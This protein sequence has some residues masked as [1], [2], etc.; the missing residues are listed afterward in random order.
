MTAGSPDGRAG[1]WP[2]PGTPGN[3]GSATGHA[4]LYQALRDQY[5]VHSAP[6]PVTVER[7]LL[8][9]EPAFTGREAELAELA[10][11]AESAGSAEPAGAGRVAI[12]TIDGMPGVGKT[13][14]ALRAAH[15]LAGHYPDGQI[16]LRL[17]AHSAGHRP[18]DPAEA[19][20]EL[21]RGAGVDPRDLPEGLDARAALWRDRLAGRRVLLVLDDAEGPAQIEPLLPGTGGCLVLVTSRRRVAALDGATPMALDTLPPGDAVRLFARLARREPLAG[22]A[23]D[24]AR[25]LVAL[26]GRLPLAV[27]LL[28]GRLAH[29]PTWDLAEFTAELSAAHDRLGQLAAGERAVAAAFETSYRA[30]PT[31]RR[32]LFRRLGLHPGT[33]TEARATAA[34]V[35]LP[36]A[37]AGEALEALYDDHLVDSP[38]RG[39]YQLHDLMHV[40]ARD[41]ALRDPEDDRERAV[42]RLLDHYGHAAERADQH[43][44]E[45]PRPT[46]AIGPAAPD[47]TRDTV[48]ELADRERALAWMRAERANLVACARHATAAGEGPRALRLTAALAAFLNLQG[49]WDE[50]AGLQRAAATVARAVGDRRAEAGALREEG[51]VRAVTGDYAAAA[52]LARRAGELYA[53]V[54]DGLGEAVTLVELGRTHAMTGE[55]APAADLFR[56]ALARYTALDS[57]EGQAHAR[58]DFGQLLMVT[59]D[60]AGAA[61]HLAASL[62]RYRELDDRQG[63]AHALRE[64]GRVRVLSGDLDAAVGLFEQAIDLYRE[65]GGR[66]GEA[67]ALGELGRARL[68]TGEPSAAADLAQQV[69]DLCRELGSR[70]GEAT[71]LLELGRARV[72]TGELPAAERLCR[73]SLGLFTTLGNTHGEAHALHELGRVSL[74][75]GDLPAARQGLDRALTRFERVGDRLGEAGVLNSVGGALLA[76][77]DPAGALAHHERALALARRINS[78]LDTAHALEGVARAHARTGNTA[79]AVAALGEAVAHYPRL[80]AA[81]APAAA[82]LAELRAGPTDRPAG[83]DATP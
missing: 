47:T 58:R 54:G 24:A 25:E 80:G 2:P 45:R 10:A 57:R 73:R 39:R 49:P 20:A 48:P 55:F 82:L 8:R 53:A 11:L 56:R 75:A 61:D 19:L 66:H 68:L 44:A 27:V 76:A 78:P 38:V 69:L 43:L 28:A 60:I 59:G 16:F 36:V 70:H 42:G 23:A 51:R 81:A 17:H 5:I 65:V 74:A 3:E 72:A 26:C 79:A 46:P 83:H 77:D 13:A 52:D 63:Q 12:R 6:A 33:D 21:L 37:A 62:A 32:L 35:D 4:R 71:A 22:A 30:L 14:L 40:Y 41:L 7:T 1:G 29:R 64:L 31:E 50:A 67:A 9:E 34:L 15:R 18:V